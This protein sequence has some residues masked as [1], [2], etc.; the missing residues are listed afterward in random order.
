MGLIKAVPISPIMK[1][2]DEE[3]PSKV[4][5]KICCSFENLAVKSF[6]FSALNSEFS[7]EQQISVLFK[8]ENEDPSTNA[9]AEVPQPAEIIID[10]EESEVQ[11]RLNYKDR[12]LN[13]KTICQWH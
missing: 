5:P 7:N 4:S 10:D 13:F 11:R 8:A 2:K 9:E 1:K 3:E 6:T 12:R